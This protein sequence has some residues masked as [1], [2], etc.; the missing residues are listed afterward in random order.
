MEER[1][2]NENESL[3]LISQMIRNTQRRI[4]S[5]NGMPFLV[6]G[7]TSVIVSLAVWF[8]LKSSS[9]Y[10]WNYLWFLIPVIGYPTMMV[11]LKK[12]SSG[13]RTMIDKFI[14]YVWL[15]IGIAAFIVSVST[16]F[17]WQTPVLFIVLLLIGSGTLITALLIQYK[18]LIFMGAISYVSAILCLMI[19]DV[20][21]ILVFAATFLVM[22]VIP[23]H[24]LFAKNRRNHV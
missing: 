2:M 17:Y 16:F 22:M 5:H 24:I 7:Y 19:R 4:D 12:Q 1:K 8:M 21:V 3:E 23:G 6:W 9:N 11:L 20:N 10:L 14:G 18:L 15:S 13:M